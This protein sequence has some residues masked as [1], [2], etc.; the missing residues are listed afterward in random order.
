MSPLFSFASV[1]AA[2]LY[3]RRAEVQAQLRVIDA[4][5]ARLR[6]VELCGRCRACKAVAAAQWEL[7][8]EA[9]QLRR[10]ESI[11]RDELERRAALRLP[12]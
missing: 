7:D 1:P 4:R 2:A 8:Q 12:N 6:R 5:L 11:L 10:Y 9:E 3:E